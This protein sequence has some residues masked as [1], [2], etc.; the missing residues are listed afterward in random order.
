MVLQRLCINPRWVRWIL[1]LLHPHRCTIASRRT[2]TLG[3]K[4]SVD[5]SVTIHS[6]FGSTTST[7]T[8]RTDRTIGLTTFGPSWRNVWLSIRKRR[9]TSR[10]FG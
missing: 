6:I 10:T 7:G 1:P 8:S 9:A 4:R 5:T 2:S 3:K